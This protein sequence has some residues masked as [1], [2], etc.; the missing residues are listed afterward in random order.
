VR[1]PTIR[2]GLQAALDRDTRAWLDLA[3]KA[4]D[5]GFDTLYVADHLGAT[6]SPFAALT[7]A[8]LATSTLR[9]GTY[10]LNVGIRDPLTIAS[11][12][13]TLDVLSNGR[14]VLGLG[15]G[16]TPAEWT[17]TGREHPTA[18]DRVGRLVETVEV[19][20]KLLR[21]E[22]V[23]HHGR[24]VHVD[25]AYLLAPRPVQPTIPLLIGGNG[26]RVLRLAG[27]SAD[28]V[29]LTGLGRTLDDGH[30]HEVDWSDAA[31][32]RCLAHVSGAAPEQTRPVLD[33]LV[34]HVGITEHR[35]DAAVRVAEFIPGAKAAHIIG[36]P[37]TLLGTLDQLADEVV[38]HYERWGFTSYVVRADA[39][40]ATAALIDRLR[41]R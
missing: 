8:A 30:R 32:D 7:A 38:Q 17:M 22:V 23:T 28:I 31:I 4:E 9:V 25:D 26:P 37:Y 41:S 3:K 34:Q 13:A 6:A 11:D 19:V 40:D 24:F 27:R 16:H 21:G 18:A 35:V 10:V 33:A 29:S 15:A 36:S 1:V 5:S 2:F 14:F 12:A 39:L 20:T